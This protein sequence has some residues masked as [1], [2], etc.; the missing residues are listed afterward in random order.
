MVRAV[1]RVI[2]HYE[3]QGVLGIDAVGDFLDHQAYGVIVVRLHQLRGIH[4]VDG[5]TEVSGVIVHQAN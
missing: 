1:L 5:G 2:F 3:N 4:H